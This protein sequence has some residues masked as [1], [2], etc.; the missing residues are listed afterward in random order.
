M[1]ALGLHGLCGQAVLHGPRRRS[2]RDRRQVHS[3]LPGLGVERLGLEKPWRP[4]GGA[5]GALRLR[6]HP[7]WR[8]SAGLP[9]LSVADKII[10]EAS[11]APRDDEKTG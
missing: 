4:G 5:G 7:Q 8:V 9:S 11:S 2:G 6:H 1:D 3:V 10:S